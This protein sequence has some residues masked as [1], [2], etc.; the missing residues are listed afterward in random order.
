MQ[1]QQ[2]YSNNDESI[3]D[4]DSSY[5]I[6]ESIG[7]SLR[8][9]STK[10]HNKISNRY[11]H[12]L[13]YNKSDDFTDDNTDT[14][15]D[16][17]DN[18]DTDDDDDEDDENYIQNNDQPQ[19]QIPLDSTYDQT[20]Y[21][22]NQNRS[23]TSSYHFV[24]IILFGLLVIGALIML[25][26]GSIMLGYR[27][28]NITMEIDKLPKIF[29]SGDD[30]NIDSED[31]QSGDLLLF[32]SD[33][34]FKS[35]KNHA[36]DNNNE[37]ASTTKI[38]DASLIVDSI[39]MLLFGSPITHV[40]VVIRDVHTGILYCLEL[41]FGFGSNEI[42]LSNLRSK[43]KNY[44]GHIMI[45]RLMARDDH[46]DGVSDQMRK[47]ILE[48]DILTEIRDK[49]FYKAMLGVMLNPCQYD[50]LF[51][52]RDYCISSSSSISDSVSI[53][54]SDS[55]EDYD[56]LRNGNSVYTLQLRDI[57]S[58]SSRNSSSIRV[59]PKRKAICTD[60][61]LEVYYLAGITYSHSCRYYP[62]DFFSKF[63][64][65]KLTD[66]LKRPFYLGKEHILK[67]SSGSADSAKT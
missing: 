35:M 56:S 64:H 51:M 12:N 18:T 14:T 59:Y 28:S 11:D 3:V 26:Y 22:S 19:T 60:L 66:T 48:S 1:Q 20:L 40:G 42:K 58:G 27:L 61:V 23:V 30:H 25:I 38:V 34:H 53:S 17:T 15:D 52:L 67:F 8:S 55:V 31:I 54:S 41:H 49:A 2:Q 24:G 46:S 10:D 65:I 13:I 4:E 33:I 37:S 16:T 45:R 43:I 62:S 57:V 36:K 39:Q 5:M 29:I 32:S 9:N 63:D 44:P 21:I 47:R 50:L 6:C 7:A